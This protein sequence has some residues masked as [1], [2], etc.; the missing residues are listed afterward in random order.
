MKSVTAKLAGMRKP[1]MFTVYPRQSDTA[2][3]VVQSDRAIGEFDPAT[4]VGVLNWRAS[5]SK[6]FFHLS[7]AAGAERYTFPPDFVA[8][9]IAAVPKSGAAIGGGVVVA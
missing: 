3:V 6:Y 1:Q 2:K 4:G 8:Q 7:F 5:G 9:C